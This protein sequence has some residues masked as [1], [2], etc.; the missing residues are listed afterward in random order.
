MRFLERFLLRLTFPRFRRS[1]ITFDSWGSR[2]GKAFTLE[3]ER[4][5][6]NEEHKERDKQQT[7]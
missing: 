7:T 4:D 2:K 6:K 3:R 5:E 1:Y